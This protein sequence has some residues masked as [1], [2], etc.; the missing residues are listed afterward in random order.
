MRPSVLESM[1][2]FIVPLDV[3]KVECFTNPRILKTRADNDA[4]GIIH[5]LTNEVVELS[6]RPIFRAY[7]ESCVGIVKEVKLHS[8]SSDEKV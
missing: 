3:K 5:D 2:W 4:I 1:R 8:R 6:P 7:L